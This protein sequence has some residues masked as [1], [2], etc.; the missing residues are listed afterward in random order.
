MPRR[1]P[2]SALLAPP[3][4]SQLSDPRL[5]PNAD[6]RASAELCA[7]A[8]TCVIAMRCARAGGH[9][10]K[11]TTEAQHAKNE[12]SARTTRRLQPRL[13]PL[14]ALEA[15]LRTALDS[16]AHVE[17]GQ[18]AREIFAS[19]ALPEAFVHA[20]RALAAAARASPEAYFELT[21]DA[22]RERLPA[23]AQR[24]S[25]S[26]EAVLVR[27]RKFCALN[28]VATRLAAEQPDII[29]LLLQCMRSA[30][31]VF[32]H[33][34]ILAE[35]LLAVSP[36]V[37]DLA[38][39][40]DL[41]DFYSLISTLSPID[42][43]HLCRVLSHV[44]FE[45]DTG[46]A[47]PLRILSPSELVASR[48]VCYWFNTSPLDRN[49]AVLVRSKLFINR[50]VSLLRLPTLAHDQLSIVL[51]VPG[52]SEEEGHG[53]GGLVEHPNPAFAAGGSLVIDGIMMEIH[54]EME[55]GERDAETDVSLHH[56]N[57][58][59]VAGLMS[60]ISEA[61]D[62][63]DA[64]SR[65]VAQQST[66][67][68]ENRRLHTF[69]QSIF[70]H[71]LLSTALLGLHHDGDEI[72][73]DS[74]ESDHGMIPPQY[75][76]LDLASNQM[77]VMI[78][79]CSVLGGN[80]SADAQAMLTRSGLASALS[81]MCARLKWDRDPPPV[82]I[83][84]DE[85]GCSTDAALK[86]HFLRLVSCFGEGDASACK[87]IF[88]SEHELDLVDSKDSS[89][90]L[91]NVEPIRLF[92]DGA[93]GSCSAASDGVSKSQRITERFQNFSSSFD[94]DLDSS[95]PVAIDVRYLGGSVN[96]GAGH[97]H[98]PRED[99]V[100]QAMSPGRLGGAPF[101]N[102]RTSATASLETGFPD[103]DM[104]LASRL[105]EIIVRYPHSKHIFCVSS[106]LESVIRG[107]SS[108]TKLLLARRGLLPALIHVITS[109]DCGAVSSESSLQ[110]QFDL[111][112][113]LIK[114]NRDLFNLMNRDCLY[115]RGIGKVF[116]LASK[117]LVD[118]NV[119]VRS[120][121]LS[122]QRFGEEDG[123]ALKYGV[124]D[125]AFYDHDDCKFFEYLENN[126]TRL[127]LDLLYVV[128]VFSHENIC[129]LNTALLFLFA[130]PRDIIELLNEMEWLS[131]D[132][133]SCG[134][135][136]RAEVGRSP[137]PVII[138][139][140]ELVEFWR[141]F[142]VY[143]PLDVS[144][145]ETSSAISFEGWSQGIDEIE[146]AVRACEESS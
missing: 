43:S 67:R 1:R 129:C 113:E 25:A 73:I 81:D 5:R 97:I 61:A 103:I 68:E 71:D 120:M 14:D 141:E 124:K 96:A 2:A 39:N 53:E 91:E 109:T 41:T 15:T 38:A 112:G 64:L 56:D 107:C 104:G 137:L 122:L 16:C 110:A 24:I 48:K 58:G 78:I 100:D 23:V 4:F 126:A 86:V 65:L 35:T 105:V 99:H 106:S 87:R 11:P 121:F 139:V 95:S 20:L 21:H 46:I 118:S 88:F 146:S 133:G 9:P 93:S 79:L 80:R 27:L 51:D 135:R 12:R 85:C 54:P 36:S 83:H 145:L 142:Y 114:H 40:L 144:N 77:D 90:I 26:L 33:A 34:V 76:L 82:P 89:R 44:V 55:E 127:L 7:A 29:R 45:P 49:H 32:H 70:A 125:H 42:L 17:R 13:S 74:I 102:P 37:Y 116:A 140:R 72:V 8:R 66:L 115:F 30:P 84:G 10:L 60:L 123:L 138:R 31:A 136:A 134:L 50:L 62:D 52:L 19:C 6:H 98:V 131:T 63:W 111:L 28:F 119:F 22:P 101:Q 3:Q 18:S 108:H 143:R 57:S 59:D 130:G 92:G 117:N 132:D 75:K 94:F 128:D 47:E 69:H